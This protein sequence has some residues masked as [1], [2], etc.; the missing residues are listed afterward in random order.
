MQR[1]TNL[2]LSHS[3]SEDSAVLSAGTV[4]AGAVDIWLIIRP[5]S[6]P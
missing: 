5:S 6:V 3:I 4:L 2:M 1:V